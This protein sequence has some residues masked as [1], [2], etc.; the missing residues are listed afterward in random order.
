MSILCVPII[1]PKCSREK[2][3]IFRIMS[4]CLDQSS[5][6]YC[7]AHEMWEKMYGLVKNHYLNHSDKLL[8]LIDQ[9]DIYRTFKSFENVEE[10]G[11][12]EDY[13]NKE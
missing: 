5:V 9:S 1:I 7:F 12:R 11:H 8:L 4:S 6:Y 3:I 13:V 10:K 2:E